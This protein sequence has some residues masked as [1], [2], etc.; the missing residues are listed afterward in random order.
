MDVN[1]I[2]TGPTNRPA[3]I[4]PMVSNILLQSIVNISP[5]ATISVNIT[6]AT[7]NDIKFLIPY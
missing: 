5:M 1:N 3:K 4:I 2:R 6:A 7:L